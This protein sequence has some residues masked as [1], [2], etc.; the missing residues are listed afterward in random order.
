LKNKVIKKMTIE[1]RLIEISNR[2]H[3]NYID[4]KNI[5][6]ENLDINN[7]EK[8]L[9]LKDAASK[10]KESTEIIENILNILRKK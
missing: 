1:N 3:N 8:I 4:I 5:Y 7:Q 9:L 2:L 10:I 6:F